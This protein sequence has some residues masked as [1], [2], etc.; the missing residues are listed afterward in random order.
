MAPSY[1][2]MVAAIVGILLLAGKR[3]TADRPL[4]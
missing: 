3:E 1:L 2:L 4:K